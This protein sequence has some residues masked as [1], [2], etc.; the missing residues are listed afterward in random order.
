MDSEFQTN[1]HGLNMTYSAGLTIDVAAEQET[2]H[3]APHAAAEVHDLFFEGMG[4]QCLAE[5]EFE[6]LDLERLSK[7]QK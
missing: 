5:C 6:F 1:E 3:L 4:F 2:I 7:K